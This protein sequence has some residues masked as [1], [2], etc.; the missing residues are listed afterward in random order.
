MTLARNKTWGEHT[1][2]EHPNPNLLV[3]GTHNDGLVLLRCVSDDDAFDLLVEAFDAVAETRGGRLGYGDGYQDGL[4]HRRLENTKRRLA[5]GLLQS[6]QTCALELRTVTNN[7][8][9]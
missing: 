1:F 9:N 3:R 8:H 7:P 5:A 4:R 2:S 6:P